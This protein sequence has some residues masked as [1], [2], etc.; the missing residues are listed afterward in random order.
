MRNS[1]SLSSRDDFTAGLPQRRPTLT[2]VSEA[3]RNEI[4][5][6]GHRRKGTLV[7]RT[8]ALR[9]WLITGLVTAFAATPAL[10]S[11]GYESANAIAG[12]AQS[13]DG[14]SGFRSVSAI[15]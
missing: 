14:E 9:V 3:R 13:S 2:A 15:T 11:G 12:S 1:K 5:A 4:A 6:G 10:A 7:T 8:N